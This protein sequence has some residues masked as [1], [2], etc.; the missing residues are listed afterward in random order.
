[1][2]KAKPVI[3]GIQLMDQTMWLRASVDGEDYIITL[4]HLQTSLFEQICIAIKNGYSSIDA[5][6][7]NDQT[8][9]HHAESQCLSKQAIRNQ[10]ER[11]VLWLVTYWL[12]SKVR[13]RSLCDFLSTLTCTILIVLTNDTW[14]YKCLADSRSERLPVRVCDLCVFVPWVMVSFHSL[15]AS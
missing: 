4:S 6:R 10:Q 3:S 2:I 14:G 8:C 1:M 13:C 11:F 12:R 9:L 7:K 15:V 5:S